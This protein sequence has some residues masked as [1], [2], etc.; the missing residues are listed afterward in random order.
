M[1][2]S[3]TAAQRPDALASVESGGTT[4]TYR[5]LDDA[6]R[7]LASL[8]AA[9]GLVPGDT[10]AILLPNS[11]L[12]CVA[13]W[14]AQRAGLYFVP[15]NWHLTAAEAVHIARDSGA[16]ALITEMALA[17]LAVQLS[18]A[19]PGLRIR[20]AAG[21]AIAEFEAFADAVADASP[22]RPATEPNGHYLFY[23]SGT[24]GRPKGV[25]PA[26][27][28]TTFGTPLGVEPLLA[29]RF[30]FDE[31]TRYLS[32][33]PM[34]HA[35]PLGWSLGTQS[36]GGTAVLMDR[37]DPESCLALIEQY[38]IT[39]A[40]FVP[41]MFT[42]M[43]RLPEDVRAAYDLSSLQVVVHAAAPCPPTVKRAMIDW[44]GPI[45]HEYYAAS[46]GNGF[47]TVDSR[48]W[49]AHPGTVGRAL[50][51]IPH[52]VDEDGQEVATGQIGQIWVDSPRDFEY[53][54]DPEQTAR[55]H[56]HRGW[57]TIG[58]LGYLDEDGYLFLVDRRADL[59]I[60]GGVNIYP[61]EVEEA[62]AMHPAVADA[63]VVGAPDDDLGQVVVA[64][65]ETIAG[66][67]GDDALVAELLDHAGRTLARFK[68]PRRT[69]FVES[70]PRLPSGKI[71]RREVRAYLS[72]A[73]GS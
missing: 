2:L 8:F 35:A 68:L 13:A 32:T 15:V 12:F 66:V 60:S 40:Q 67:T 23:S 28:P 31:T 59:I 47:F 45:V 46:E 25:K 42:R 61:R 65:V 70:L 71:L 3:L 20:L 16:T 55:A 73:S 38:R 18:D 52:I 7:R 56:D 1:H 4:M 72:A 14:G 9:R 39:H 36:L 62:L 41:T 5:A 63:A 26:L 29:E 44:F 69:V 19:C 43:L 49:L 10:V 48:E 30:G 27:P 57:S 64:A 58:D 11:A 34:Y 51:G 37:F 53:H 33:G 21:G 22:T 54:N 24:T 17:G 50:V 6:S